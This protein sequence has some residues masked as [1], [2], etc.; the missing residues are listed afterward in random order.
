MHKNW[1]I[2]FFGNAKYAIELP[3]TKVRLMFHELHLF[4]DKFKGVNS[5]FSAH[6]SYY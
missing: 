5:D 6:Y 3:F 4:F 2:S 1:K